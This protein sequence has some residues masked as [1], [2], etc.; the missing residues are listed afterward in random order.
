L[1]AGADLGAYPAPLVDPIAAARDAKERLTTL[2]RAEGYRDAAR[3]V[4][5][6][7]GSR[8]RRLENDNPRRPRPA[9]KGAPK[10]PAQLSLAF[11][12]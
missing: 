7:H 2:R 5:Q 8:K 9:R 3:E 12:D 1:A 11:D 6:K 4:F 10:A